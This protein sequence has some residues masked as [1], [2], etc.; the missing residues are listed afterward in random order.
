[1]GLNL[2]GVAQ[3][4]NAT[5]LWRVCYASFLASQ[6]EERAPL[7]L[8]TGTLV[9]QPRA[10][11]LSPAVKVLLRRCLVASGTAEQSVWTACGEYGVVWRSCTKCGSQKVKG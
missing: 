9:N 11:Q 6:S 10:S 5:P 4:E 8:A 3:S 2:R 7:S 1:M